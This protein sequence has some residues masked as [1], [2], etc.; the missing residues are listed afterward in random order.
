MCQCV[1]EWVCV[2][3]SVCERNWDRQKNKK[4]KNIK[5][6][7]WNTGYLHHSPDYRECSHIHFLNHISRLHAEIF[8]VSSSI[9]K[10]LRS[11]DSL[12]EKS[13]IFL[14]EEL[15]YCYI[16]IET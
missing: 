5:L 9:P 10:C 16:K 11:A 8:F 4:Q 3:K 7:D 13:H 14:Q 12:L 1:Q 6:V 15:L 2:C